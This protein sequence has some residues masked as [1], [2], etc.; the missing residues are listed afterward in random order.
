MSTSILIEKEY[1]K[2]P[3]S[4]ST[5]VSIPAN[6]PLI[7]TRGVES[8]GSTSEK[9][10]FLED[11]VASALE[12]FGFS[13]ESPKRIHSKSG[14]TIEVD[15][16][17]EKNIEGLKFIVYAS[18]KNWEKPVDAGWIR[19]E[20]ERIAQMPTKPHMTIMVAPRFTDPAKDEAINNGFIV[21]ETGEEVNKG[22][23]ERISLEIYE[24]LGKLF[25][26]P[27]ALKCGKEFKDLILEKLS[28]SKKVTIVSPQI[29]EET[30]GILIDLASKGVEISLITTSDPKPSHI[31]GLSKLIRVERRTRRPAL[32]FL[33]ISIIGLPLIMLPPLSLLGVLLLVT[34][35]PL[36]LKYRIEEHYYPKIKEL[37]VTPTKLNARLILTDNAVGVGSLDF[38][39][40][41]LTTNIKCFT[42]IKEPS[43]YR[44]AVE[45]V[46]MLKSTIQKEALEYKSIYNIIKK[47]T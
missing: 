35:I 23:K 8:L 31:R 9:G 30:A 41:G 33:L 26:A 13:V 18:C 28:S 37:I 3:N 32:I 38:T 40:A 42:W 45:D 47:L 15:A 29:S 24:K 46:N 19:D 11:A 5:E 20:L 10:R 36:Y 22:N 6:L 43:T 44:R 25:V 2:T 4:R 16:W 21:I 39:E 7:L 34:G 27:I 12:R 17:G 14:G 1:A